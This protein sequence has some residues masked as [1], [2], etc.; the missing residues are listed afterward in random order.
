MW[1]LPQR[2]ATLSPARRC[3][4]ALVKTAR[5]EAV[6]VYRRSFDRIRPKC[7]KN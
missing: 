2:R 5:S 4:A 3:A 6:R 1:W 7:L